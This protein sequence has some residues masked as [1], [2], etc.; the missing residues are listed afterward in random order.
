MSTTFADVVPIRQL[1]SHAYAID[2]ADEWCIGNGLY[3]G[4]FPDIYNGLWY[5]RNDS[6]SDT[7]V[8]Q[9]SMAAMLRRPSY[10]SLAPTCP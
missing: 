1:T 2:L 6:L 9:F 3:I 7:G 4:P 8:V 10:S 5:S